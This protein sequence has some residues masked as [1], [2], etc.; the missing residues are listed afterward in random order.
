MATLD[1]APIRERLF[2]DRAAIGEQIVAKLE[3]AKTAPPEQALGELGQAL[4]LASEREALDE[5]LAKLGA[6]DASASAY[7]ER[8]E[9]E[10]R[11]AEVKDLLPIQ[12]ESYEMHPESGEIGS[13]SDI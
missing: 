7:P 9:I 12:I 4:H 13:F 11:L 3:I 10:R 5:R 6:S 8:A 1:R 2:A